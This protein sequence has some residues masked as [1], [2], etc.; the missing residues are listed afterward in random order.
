MGWPS[1]QELSD[2]VRHFD[3]VNVNRCREGW[4]YACAKP[5]TQPVIR[6][7]SISRYFIV[8]IAIPTPEEKLPASEGGD[9]WLTFYL[10]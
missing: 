4:A 3:G 9:R 8:T 1:R 2:F 6:R 10:L 7:R 5:T